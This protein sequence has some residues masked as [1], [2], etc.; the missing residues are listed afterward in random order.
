MMAAAAVPA[1]PLNAVRDVLSVVGFNPASANRFILAHDLS[2]MDN[3][4]FM[5]YYDVEQTLKIYNDCQTGNN[6]NQKI[7]YPVQRKLQGFLY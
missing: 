3:S 1:D 7:G 5:P 6:T 2:V 4:E